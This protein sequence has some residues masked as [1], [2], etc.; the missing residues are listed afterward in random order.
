MKKGYKS[1]HWFKGGISEWRRFNYPLFVD[2]KYAQ[3]RPVKVTPK[4][5]K[6]MLDLEKIFVLDVRPQNF[7]KGP[8]FIVASYH[9][10]LL[11]IID[12]M[13]EF[14]KDK[15]III[16]DWAMRQSPLAAKY[17]MANGFENV[18]GVVKGGIERW[19]QDGLPTEERVV[20][21]K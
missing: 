8:K 11:N 7:A 12:R 6:T 4:K 13:A 2:K 19:V 15:P 3:Y 14:P 20:K 17:L 9:C 5:V 18:V 16:S 21:S 10:P 1:V